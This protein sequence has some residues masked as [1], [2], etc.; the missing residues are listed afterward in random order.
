[1]WL[2]YVPSKV[3]DKGWR[4]VQ[5]GPDLGVKM[6]RSCSRGQAGGQPMVEVRNDSG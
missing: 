6:R 2:A 3:R 5:A 1:M 4:G